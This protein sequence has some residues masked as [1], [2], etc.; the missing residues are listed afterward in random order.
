VTGGLSVL[1]TIQVRGEERRGGGG[2]EL[3]AIRFGDP[4]GQGQSHWQSR[5]GLLPQQG[6]QI[7]RPTTGGC[8]QVLMLWMKM[9]YFS[10]VFQSNST[11]FVDTLKVGGGPALRCA[12]LG[13]TSSCIVNLPA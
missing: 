8:L 13:C 7:C 12:S 10:R 6:G 2:Q 3:L 1:L 4:F 9:Q 11:A 5:A